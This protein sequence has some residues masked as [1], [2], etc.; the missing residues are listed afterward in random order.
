[1]PNVSQLERFII[2]HDKDQDTVLNFHE[3][4]RAI[5]PKNEAYIIVPTL[6]NEKYNTYSS[7]NNQYS[8]D[9]KSYIEQHM[10]NEWKEDLKE[11]IS[12]GARAEE[13]M[14][15]IRDSLE[16]DGDQVFS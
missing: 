5:T 2:R 4:Q 7:S 10:I 13:I 11:L 9:S 8:T 14:I 3:F 6:R 12:T 1:M 15:S 16:I